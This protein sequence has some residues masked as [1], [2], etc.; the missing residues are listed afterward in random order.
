MKIMNKTGKGFLRKGI[1]LSAMLAMVAISVPGA[2]ARVTSKALGGELEMTGFLSEESRFRLDDGGYLSQQIIRLQMEMSLNYESKGIFDTLSVVTVLRPEFDAAYYYGRSLT[3]G[4]VGRGANRPSSQGI[5]FTLANDPI[6][7][8][9]FGA[10]LSTGGLSKNV[11][12]G[13]WDASRLSEFEAI[14]SNTAFPLP[15]PIS[16]RPLDCKGCI[17]VNDSATNVAFG[18]TGSS[19]SLYPIREFYVDAEIGDLWLR[20]GKQQIVWGKTDFFRMQDIINPVDFGSHLFFDSFEDIRIPQW[21]AS[22]QYKT[23]TLG[24]LEDT[25]LQIVWNFDRFR[26]VGLGSPNQAWATPFGK[27]IG[28]FAGFNTYFSPEPC[29]ST[30]TATAAGANVSTICQPGDGRL[31]SGFGIP[32]GLGTENLPEWKLSNTEIGGRFEFRLGDVRFALS[33]YYGWGDTPSFKIDTVNVNAAA[34]SVDPAL[35]NDNLIVGLAEGIQVPIAVL[36]PNQAIA[37]AAA[38]G[39][40]DAIAALNADN[41]RLFYQTGKTIGGQFSIQYKRA[42]T[43]GLSFDYFEG[44]SGVVFRVESSITF[45]ELVNNT[46]KANWLDTSDVVRWSIGMDRPTFIRF[47]NPDRTFFLSAQLFD[48]WYVDQE[49][50]SN[51]GYYVG[52]HN[53]IATFFAQTH[54]LRDQ[55]IP[56]GFVV[57]EEQ[58]NSWV[59]GAS[60]EYLFNN[61]VSITT[62]FNLIWGGKRNITHDVGPFTSFTLDGNYSQEAIFGIGRQGLGAFRKNDELFMRLK[63]QW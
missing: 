22:F 7:F 26:P 13:L 1:F 21:I 53:F 11:N 28:S 8:G 51:D 33:H 62:G 57:W 54:Y 19:G 35:V 63:Y 17:N 44:N 41:A 46:R 18:R 23:G 32:V 59:V 5:A 58:S 16:N 56:Q 15:S 45:N 25:A 38:G 36:E 47:L 3:G 10:G 9:G 31:A 61:H 50:D 48:T 24:P 42:H 2:N 4:R 20:I 60:V 12:Q 40:V 55:L 39:D 14:T 34:V 43:T 30:N 52:K 6:G 49:G 29:I 37:A 27:E